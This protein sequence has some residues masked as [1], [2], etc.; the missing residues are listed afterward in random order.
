MTSDPRAQYA[1]A[2]AERGEFAGATTVVLDLIAE[3][4]HNAEAHRAWGCLLL[5]QRKTTDAVSAFRVAADLDPQRAELQ[6]ALANSLLAEAESTPYPPLTNWVDARSAVDAGLLIA[7][8][9]PV[10]LGLR[11]RLEEHRETIV[12]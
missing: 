1:V 11:D 3:D 8:G 2:A 9:H 7:P 6:F 5:A 10:G 12:L 4:W